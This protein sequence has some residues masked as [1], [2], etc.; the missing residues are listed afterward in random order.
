MGNLP[1]PVC[2]SVPK[3]WSFPSWSWCSWSANAEGE[4]PLPE[5]RFSDRNY[6]P[7]LC[8]VTVARRNEIWQIGPV[9]GCAEF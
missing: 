1:S 8:P 2:P 7:L 6:R 9:F 5:L 4:T 3:P